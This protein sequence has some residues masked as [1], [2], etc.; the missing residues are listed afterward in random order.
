MEINRL[1]KTL[2]AITIITVLIIL[3]FSFGF[4]Y[5]NKNR[6]N[7]FFAGWLSAKNKL[8]E[9][10]FLVDP[11]EVFS[12]YGIIE[13]IEGEKII[14]S[15]N[16]INVNPLSPPTPEKR[17][18]IISEET[19]IIHQTM[20]DMETIQQEE[21]EYFALQEQ[22]LSKPDEPPPLPPNPIIEEIISIDDL[23]IGDFI[24]ISAV[25]N[26]KNATEFIATEIKK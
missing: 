19:K 18:V 12:L 11:E 20:K 7:H 25:N 22:F 8:A 3:I 26:I 13:K 16:Q 2:I 10:G 15:T 23:V 5:G 4:Y 6:E 17:T 21:K 9:T 14:I 1:T 24:Q